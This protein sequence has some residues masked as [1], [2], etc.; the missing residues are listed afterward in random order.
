MP[1]IQSSEPEQQIA[2]PA[3]FN[4]FELTA[5]G[6]IS[7]YPHLPSWA[8]EAFCGMRTAYHLGVSVED[9]ALLNIAFLPPAG[10]NRDKNDLLESYADTEIQELFETEDERD[11][12]LGHAEVCHLSRDIIRSGFLETKR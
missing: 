1:S 5:Q 7:R 6:F 3:N 4:V 8:A 9:G 2:G 11:K 10:C 12:W